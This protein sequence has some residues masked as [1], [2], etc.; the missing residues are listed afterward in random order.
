MPSRFADLGDRA[1][2]LPH[3]AHRA[4]RSGHALRVER[5]DRVDDADGGLLGLQR[6]DDRLDR[7]LASA[8]TDSASPAQPLRTQPNLRRRLLPGHVE[9]AR[10][11]PARLPSAMPVSVDLPM[12]GDPPRSTTEPGTSPP[13]STRSS[14]PMPVSRRSASGASTSRSGTGLG[15]EPGARA[16]PAGS[17]LPSGARLDQGVPLAAARAAARP[18]K[19]GVPALL[20]DEAGRRRACVS[21]GGLAPTGSV[22]FTVPATRH[23]ARRHRAP[24]R[25]RCAISALRE[26]ALPD[27]LLFDP[28]HLRGPL[29]KLSQVRRR[30]RSA[31]RP[32]ARSVS[33]GMNLLPWR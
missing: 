6:R 15:A 4:G 24:T 26:G 28:V 29:A 25:P 2:R 14:S 16:P 33:F 30:R 22:L 20:A 19:R 18:R 3:L 27:L 32:P 8:G 21:V 7:R 31:R 9:D 5:L 17:P 12:P 10:A 1:R 11:R 13:P 23:P